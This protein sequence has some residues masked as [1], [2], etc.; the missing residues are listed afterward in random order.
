[1]KNFLI[2]FCFFVLRATFHV[3]LGDHD[4]TK[5]EGCEQIIS[6]SMVIP[7]PQYNSYTKEN[8]VMLIRLAVR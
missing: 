2:D 6:V 4:K 8:D 7:H 5:V 1:M 3:V